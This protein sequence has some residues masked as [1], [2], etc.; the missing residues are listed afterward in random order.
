VDKPTDQEW[1][2][3]P[4]WEQ[5]YEVSDLGNVW[6][7][8]K[9]RPLKPGLSNGY[10]MVVLCDSGHRVSVKTANLVAQAFIGPRPFGQDIRHLDG[11]STNDT[12]SNLC[13]GTHRENML[14]TV[15]HGTNHNARKT[16]CD[17]D[18]E[19]TPAN[20]Y[21]WR[22]KRQCRMCQRDKMRRLRT[23]DHARDLHCD[24]ADVRLGA[25]IQL[26]LE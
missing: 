4:G 5:F 16:H 1:R 11:N 13:Y 17:S 7:I 19:F 23:S 3:V 20:T 2:P 9:R 12:R 8:R 10:Y 18:H 14:D 21:M 15:R 22:G 6:S 24:D 25:E 26:Y